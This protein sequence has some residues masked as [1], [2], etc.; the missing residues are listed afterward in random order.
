MAAMN[1]G[2]GL[3]YW[4]PS[5]VCACFWCFALAV[6]TDFLASFGITF[7]TAGLLVV[8]PALLMP[9]Y[10][11]LLCV[12]LSGFVVDASLP[13]AFE[14]THS[15]SFWETDRYVSL[16]GDIATDVPAFFGFVA[17][18]MIF[19]YLILRLLRSRIS[20]VDPIRWIVCAEIVNTGIFVFWAIAM[21]WTRFDDFAYWGGVLANLFF[22]SLVIFVFGWWF[23]DLQLSAYRIFGID[24]VREREGEGE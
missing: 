8:I 11:G 9:F 3:F 19:A 7:F 23:F 21:G 22:S 20:V 16:F 18:W 12:L 17:G 15:L 1:F 10:G 4:V 24:V 2:K 6:L 13:V 5:L 14:K